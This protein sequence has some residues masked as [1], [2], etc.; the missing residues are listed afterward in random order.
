[1][2][3]YTSRN[4]RATYVCDASVREKVHRTIPV[5]RLCLEKNAPDVVA[6]RSSRCARPRRTGAA[7]SKLGTRINNGRRVSL[8][9]CKPRRPTRPACRAFT[10]PAWAAADA[11]IAIPPYHCSPREIAKPPRATI[12]ATTDLTDALV[13]IGSCLVRRFRRRFDV[14]VNRTES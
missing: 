7:G 4:P 8:P 9:L 13:V 14:A 6:P 10:I 11:L 3:T 5:F 1:M 2:P 12:V